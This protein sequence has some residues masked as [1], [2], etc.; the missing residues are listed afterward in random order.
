[1]QIP[2]AACGP[3]AHDRRQSSSPSARLTRTRWRVNAPSISPPSS[4]A[5]RPSGQAILPFFR[6]AL[7]DREQG[8]PRRL[9]PRDG[10]RPGRRGRPAPADRR[11]LP[12]HGIVGEEFGTERAGRRVCLGARSDRRHARLHLR[13]AALGHADRAHAQRRAGLRDDAPALHRRALLRRWRQRRATPARPASARSR[14]AAAARSRTPRSDD[15]PEPVRGRRATGLSPGRGRGAARPLRRRLLR[16]RMVAAGPDGRRDRDRPQALRHR[17]P[18]P[19]R[20]RRGRHRDHLGRRISRR[21][22]PRSWPPAT[23]CSTPRSS[24]S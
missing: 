13:P 8:R 24:T 6:A 1:M 20:R 4:T 14:R 2:A 7:R 10:G 12:E 23:A 18:D 3:A 17:G 15:E 9:R 16:L 5:S 22:R 11:G 19:H 21:R